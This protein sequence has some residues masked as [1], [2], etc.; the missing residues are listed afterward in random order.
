MCGNLFERQAPDFIMGS[1]WDKEYGL[2]TQILA[3]LAERNLYGMAAGPRQKPESGD[4]L[5]G[6][7]GK[8]CAG[9]QAVDSVG[10]SLGHGTERRRRA[11]EPYWSFG[12]LCLY[13]GQIMKEG[14]KGGTGMIDRNKV[15][16]AVRLLLEGMGEDPSR[17]GVD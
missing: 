4:T 2:M 13:L 1:V 12:S 16:Q 11:G 7:A 14:Q 15:E 17:E 5:Q 10:N 9:T 6:E 3:P 8:Y